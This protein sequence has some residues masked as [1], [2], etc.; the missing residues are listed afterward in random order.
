[1]E[2]QILKEILQEM[3]GLRTDVSSTNERLDSVINEAEKTNKRLD[4]LFQSFVVLQDGIAGVRRDLQGI[5]EI[6]A[7]KVIWHNDNIIIETEE[8]KSF[9]GIIHREG[10]K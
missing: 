1:M 2:E 4:G 3:K 9:K 5:K 10:R 7:E 8:G 6:L